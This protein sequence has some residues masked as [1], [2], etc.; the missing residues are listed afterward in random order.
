MSLIQLVRIL[1]ARRWLIAFAVFLGLLV[2]V[3]I[4]NLLPARY[5]ARARVLMDNFKPDPV[6]G[7]VLNASGIKMFI[8]TQLELIK[9]YRIAGEAVDRLG[10]TSNANLL[11]TWQAET[12]GYG[13]FRRWL[14]DR[15]VNNVQVSQ[16]ESS[17][18]MEIT[19]EAGV[20]E[21]A[22]RTVNAL[23]D[24]YIENSL[25]FRTDSAGRT[26]EW[27]REQAARALRVLQSAEAAKTKFEQDNGIVMTG[28][29]EAETLKLASLQAALTEARSNAGMQSFEAVRQST[30]SSVV[31]QLKVQ[32]ATLNDQ[33]EQA[34][35]RLGNQHPTYLAMLSRRTQLERQ[36]AREQV[37]ARQA[38]AAQLG[39]SRGGVAQLEAEYEAQ[40][41]KVF[42]MKEKLDKLGQLTSEVELRR[43]Q[44]E[45]AAKR[46]SELQL[47]SNVADAGLIVLGDA[48]VS[49]DPTFPNWSLIIPL[50]AGIG[51]SVGVLM[52]LL[53]ELLNRRVRGAEDLGFAAR[54]PVF[55]VV[56]DQQTPEWQRLIKRL[57]IRRNGRNEQFQPA[58]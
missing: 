50:A 12:G 18:I 47:E 44:Y 13:D 26:A 28:T 43:Q 1:V 7:A 41:A 23:R 58:Q 20:P 36:L 11:A 53:V 5:P 35:E 31:D 48:I 21:V 16:I 3:A 56:A 42:A 2:G 6:T 10:L 55:A 19:Y 52:A 37:A 49:P 14:A 22:R 33:I 40:R 8:R 46:T 9:D 57:L 29:G 51:L 32:L 39:A 38:G 25:K 45:Q 30:N 15:I 34:S 27:Y 17:N 4:G 54:V 24:A